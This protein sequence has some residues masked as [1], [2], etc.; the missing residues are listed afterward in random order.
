MNIS[1]KLHIEIRERNISLQPN[2]M[3]IRSLLCYG[4]A[5]LLTSAV[6]TLLWDRL[7]EGGRILCFAIVTYF[8]AHGLFD[9][10]FRLN[11]RYI[12]DKDNNAIYKEN[13]PFGIR[14][15]MKLDEAIIFTSSESG[16]WHYSL[17]VKKKQFLKS[18][19][20]S[21][22]F[23][24]RKASQKLAAA[25]EKEILAPIIDLIEP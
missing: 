4:V 3:V 23:G 1:D 8:L 13:V 6:L 12:F 10:T 14:Q 18:Y 25:Y 16:D 24:S 9:I 5:I 17:G 20:I 22:C 7:G 21:P 11:V 19:K 2:R 15:L